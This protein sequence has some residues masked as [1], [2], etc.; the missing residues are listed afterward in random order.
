MTADPVPAGPEPAA[1]LCDFDVPDAELR[2]AGSVK[3]TYQPPDV[4]P[5]WVA[6]MDCRP[7]PPVL[8]AVRAAVDRGMFGYPALPRH[9]DL[10]EATAAFLRRRFGWAV[11]P[12]RV[13]PTGD[14]MAGV[15]L[16]LETLCADAPVV[17]PTPTYPPFLD[18]VPLAGR[19]VVQVPCVVDGAGRPVLDLDAV[20]AAF[21]AGARTVLLAAPHNP[22]GRAFTPAELAGLRDVVTRYEGG[23]VLSDEIHAPLALPGAVHT[24]YAAVEGTADHVTTIVAASKAWN[25]PGL[26]CAQ[27]V[28]GNAADLAALTGVAHVANHG[29]SP[30]GVVATVAAYTEGEPWLDSLMA[31]LGAQRDLFGDLLAAH[32]PDARWTPMEATYLA[33]VDARAYGLPDPAAAALRDGK[34]CV[35]PGRDFGDGYT[36]YV[37]VNLATSAER[38]TEVVRR[39]SKAWPARTV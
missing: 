12:A 27:V 15:R 10:P 17:V 26:K 33:W 7:C 36:G 1:A 31:H 14:V 32:L 25:I 29:L 34:V 3:W 11:D 37:R 21:A 9:T 5:A 28:A 20:D 19:Q 18:V 4:L 13:L 16:V 38:L 22:L 35:N 23:R 24:P 2:A 39:L 6:E 30:L 8:D